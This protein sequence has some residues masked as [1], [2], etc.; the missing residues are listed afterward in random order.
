MSANKI[1]ALIAM[2]ASLSRLIIAPTEPLIFWCF[3]A[4]SL[5]YVYERNREVEI[6]EK[7]QSQTIDDSKVT[8]SVLSQMESFEKFQREITSKVDALNLNAGIKRLG[9]K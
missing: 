6:Q 7:I 8:K 2:A 9:Q 5:L 1:I 4:A 3:I